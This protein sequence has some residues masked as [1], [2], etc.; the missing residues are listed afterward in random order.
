S[1]LILDAPNPQPRSWGL[2]PNATAG[3]SAPSQYGKYSEWRN[4]ASL[5]GPMTGQNFTAVRVGDVVPNPPSM[6]GSNAEIRYAGTPLVWKLKDAALREGETVEAVFRAEQM[7]D[8][9]GWQFG[10]RFDPTYLQAEEIATTP[11]LP[12]DPAVNFGLYQAELGEIR[13]L[14]ADADKQSLENGEQVFT[15]RFKVRKGGAK[16]SEVLQLDNAVLECFAL[17][18]NLDPVAVLLSFEDIRPSPA[19]KAAPIL[20][21]NMPNPF[22]R[23][24]RVRFELP[25]D[26]DVRL[27]IHDVNGRLIKELNG[28][29][30]KGLHE[31]RFGRGEIGPYAG[32]LYYT[33]RCGEFTV[34]RRMV[35]ID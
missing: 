2:A 17:S 26:S 14:W 32:V 27:T 35:V 11:A 3:S 22:D 9:L 21:Q 20:Y 30:S 5:T 12:L 6:G 1:N 7:T 31:V 29:Y 34:T 10:L 8:L 4:Y 24:T 15:V 28:H 16:L 19:S 13:S 33:L 23:E 25:E 18:E